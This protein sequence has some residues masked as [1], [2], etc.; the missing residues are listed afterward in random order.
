MRG[1]LGKILNHKNDP[2]FVDYYQNQIF[3]GDD[4]IWMDNI[5]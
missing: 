4:D 1:L 5:N 2:E 3:Q